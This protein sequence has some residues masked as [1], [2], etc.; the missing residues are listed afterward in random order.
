MQNS[1]KNLGINFDDDRLTELILDTKSDLSE[2][3]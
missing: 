1:D 3:K 2:I